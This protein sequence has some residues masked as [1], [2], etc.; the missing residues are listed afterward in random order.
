MIAF[1]GNTRFY[2]RFQVGA[3]FVVMSNREIEIEIDIEWFVQQIVRESRSTRKRRVPIV[4]LRNDPS[5]G[6]NGACELDPID[7]HP[8]IVSRGYK[9][10]IL[11]SVTR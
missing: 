1:V 7:V 10:I 4:E 9:S 5:I 6:I 8:Q 11:G 2:L 3:A